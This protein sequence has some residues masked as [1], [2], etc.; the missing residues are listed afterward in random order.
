[1]CADFPL[2]N[3]LP[4]EVVSSEIRHEMLLQHSL[5]YVEN[6]DEVFFVSRFYFTITLYASEIKKQ[7]YS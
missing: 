7:E 5:R 3:V 6:E 4:A 1:M 2:G